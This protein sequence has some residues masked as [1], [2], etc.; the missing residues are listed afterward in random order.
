MADVVVEVAE[1]VGVVVE[2]QAAVAA[3]EG[4]EPTRAEEDRKPEAERV[5]ENEVEDEVRVGLVWC[6]QSPP[7]DA[8]CRSFRVEWTV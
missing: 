7:S 1:E 2:V 8:F 6:A 4:E 5:K 3:E